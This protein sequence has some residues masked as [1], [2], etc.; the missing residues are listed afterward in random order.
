MADEFCLKMPD[1]HITF[2]DLLHAV[3]LR[4]GTDGFTS[5]PKEGVLRIFS[6]WKIQRLR[7]GLNSRTWVAKASMLPPDHRSRLWKISAYRFVDCN[8]RST[9]DCLS[10]VLSMSTGGNRGMSVECSSGMMRSKHQTTSVPLTSFRRWTLSFNTILKI[11]YVNF[12]LIHGNP[13]EMK[14]LR[15]FHSFLLQNTLRNSKT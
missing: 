8:W 10:V 7:S 13:K 14:R 9:Y 12:D 4:H 1:F 15:T 2:R 6:P 11:V 3:N 5:P